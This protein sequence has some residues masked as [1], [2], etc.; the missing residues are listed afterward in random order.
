MWLMHDG[1]PAHF[2]RDGKQF[3]DSDYPGRWIGRNGTVWWPPRSPDLTPVVFYL[4]GHLKGKGRALKF[5]VATAVRHT[6]G[7][8]QCTG[9]SWRHRAQTCVETNGEHFQKHVQTLRRYYVEI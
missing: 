9:N 8:F 2:I 6:P 3:L 7:I 5:A 4:W 1:D